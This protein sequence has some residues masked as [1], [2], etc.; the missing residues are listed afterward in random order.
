MQATKHDG[1]L[2]NQSLTSSFHNLKT[3]TNAL[4]SP[5]MDYSAI[6]EAALSL[7]K[8]FTEAVAFDDTD[9][10]GNE[11]IRTSSGLAIGPRSAALC[12]TDMMRTRKF[13]LG[14]RDAIEERLRLN[15]G[16][17]VTVLYAGTGPFA[18]LLTP[19]ITVFRP[20]QLQMVLL[21]INPVSFYYL[22]KTMYQFGMED[23]LVDLVQADA[24]TYAIPGNQQPDIIVS[25]TMMPGLQK[26]PQVSIAANLLSQCKRN[27]VLIPDLIKVDVCL[28]GNMIN[29]PESFITLKTLL[30]LDAETAVRIK[31]NPE[32]VPALSPGIL[33]TI[34]ELP[35]SQY[36]R[37]VLITSIR[38]F[39]NHALGFKES[40]I[41]L[42]QPLM[43][44][45]TLKKYPA[46]LLFKYHI[47]SEPG[48]RVTEM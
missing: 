27:P 31:N 42:A 48:F 1:N 9:N 7:K 21:E 5:V 12:I 14:I 11:N 37:L 16:R 38:V 40:G 32:D 34:P 2:K 18:T 25:E 29:Y 15:P 22:Q 33:V 46:R 13:I 20:A 44:L 17:P 36:Y 3:I 8:L 4:L 43:D 10:S 28:A 35:A 47:E 26:E 6:R 41:T 30:E 24:V 19:L 23:Y 39:G 45:A